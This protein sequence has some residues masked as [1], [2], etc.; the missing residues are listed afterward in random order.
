MKTPLMSV[1]AGNG[2]TFKLAV[3]C[4][5]FSSF[6]FAS[7]PGFAQAAPEKGAVSE[8]GT[9]S[10][11][12][13]SEAESALKMKEPSFQTREERLNAKPLDWNATIGK[14]RPKKLTPAEREA[15][16]RARPESSAGG[17]PNPNAE[18][19]ARKLYPDDWK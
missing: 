14:P 19:E 1:L 4:V 15:L 8:K 13:G 7:T 5:V 2:L 6:I 18:Q 17:A 11:Q 3:V 12:R 16:Q 10:I 9:V